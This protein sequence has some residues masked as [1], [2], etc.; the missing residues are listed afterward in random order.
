MGKLTAKFVEGV[1]PSDKKMAYGDG[2]A[3]E[4]HVEPSKRKGCVKKWIA[5]FRWEGK[6]NSKTLGNLPDTS[7]SEARQLNMAFR[8]HL[9][10]GL[11]PALF[12][13]PKMARKAKFQKKNPDTPAPPDSPQHWTV[14]QY[15]D[16]WLKSDPNWSKNT[17]KTK[18]DRA[19][20][21]LVKP[22]GS[23]KLR[24][25]THAVIEECISSLTEEGK[26]AQAKK[27]AGVWKQLYEYAELHDKSLPNVAQNLGRYRKKRV[28]VKHHPTLVEPAAI[29]DFVVRLQDYR[30][31]YKGT[32]A[33]PHTIYGVWLVLYTMKRPHEVCEG[34]WSEIDFEQKLWRKSAENNKTGLENDECPL[35]EQA[36]YILRELHKVTGDCEY[37][38]PGGAKNLHIVPETLRKLI[39]EGL[40]YAV[41]ELTTHGLRGMFSTTGNELGFNFEAVEKQLSHNIGNEVSQAY[42]HAKYL[43]MRR[44]VVQKYA[45]WLHVQANKVW[46]KKMRVGREPKSPI[47]DQAAQIAV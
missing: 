22:H 27:V 35:S 45:D 43:K 34:R 8:A 5:R 28:K 6:A 17:V 41:G 18:S 32:K 11:H 9:D 4:L 19:E 25:I 37:M 14:K 20:K 7:L 46:K 16:K 33:L 2:D 23:T 3:L 12:V 30:P 10:Q 40:G 44:I 39:I 42:N 36:L 47:Q 1:K 24:D 31:K 26:H 15:V 29:G 21:Y 38:F 13:P